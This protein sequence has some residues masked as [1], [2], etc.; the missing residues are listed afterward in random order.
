[1]TADAF[2]LV[3]EVTGNGQ[4]ISVS[5]QGVT[6]QGKTVSCPAA[7][8]PGGGTTLPGG[9][10]VPGGPTIPTPPPIP[11]PPQLT[12]YHESSCGAG[13]DVTYF[14]IFTVTPTKTVS[15]THGVASASGLHILVTHPTP[16]P[17]VPQ[18]QTEYV[19]GEGY[20][21]A[22][23]GTGGGAPPGFGL[24]S[25]GFG[26]GDFGFNGPPGDNGLGANTAANVAPAI[27]SNRRWPLVL[28]FLT[29]EALVL[30]SAAAWVWARNAPVEEVADEVL[31]PRSPGA[32]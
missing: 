3:G 13:A 12:A 16:G 17:G 21:D 1:A 15:G 14:K 5:D 31:S 22:G 7:P 26:G 4:P 32:P 11:P 25:F 29:L 6:I 18:Q 10:T 27:F 24:G 8:T 28:L 23:T 30:G 20:A 19:L 9:T 2:V